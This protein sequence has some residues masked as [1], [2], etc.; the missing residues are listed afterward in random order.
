MRAEARTASPQEGRPVTQAALPPRP[1]EDVMG[2]QG[3]LT[4]RQKEAVDSAALEELVQV[5]QDPAVA[6]LPA[7]VISTVFLAGVKAGVAGFQVLAVDG[8]RDALGV[9]S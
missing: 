8:L 1:K 2:E 4:P 5:L 6:K 7:G 9:E 3:E